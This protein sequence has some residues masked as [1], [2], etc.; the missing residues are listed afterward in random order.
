MAERGDSDIAVRLEF[1]QNALGV[2][3]RDP[4]LLERALTHPSY[5]A[6]APEAREPYERL[7]FLGDAVLSFI[8][9]DHLFRAYPDEPEGLLTKVRVSLVAGVVL[10]H[11]AEELRLGDAILIGKA[12]AAGGVRQRALEDCFEALIG[13]L[14]LDGG[15][16]AAREFVLRTLAPRIDL[17]AAARH[18]AD[19]KS[20]LQEFLQGRG[21]DRP[22]Y[23]IV[24]Q[25]GPPHEP[26]FVAQV[27]AQ[28]QVLGM[29]T[30]SSKQVAE[31]QAAAEALRVLSGKPE[32]GE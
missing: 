24:S 11:V 7:E 16:E 1:A 26:T 14:Y 6:E 12:A 3:F 30:G 15:L 13:A 32:A 23:A 19:P 29:G 9:A 28:G 17:D 8:V 27:T 10:A 2:R 5:A 18:V 31:K 21:L 20:A 22:E 25:E 4:V